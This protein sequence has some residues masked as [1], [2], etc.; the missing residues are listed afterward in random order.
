MAEQY[1]LLKALMR[2]GEG[3]EWWEEFFVFFYQAFLENDRWMRYLEGVGSTLLVTTLAL[4][5]GLVLG[6]IVAIVRTSYAQQR[7]GKRNLL[8]GI[9]DKICGIIR[10]LAKN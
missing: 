9:L 7:P 3:V 4:A 8:L 6:I 5:I 1:E 10:E 2:S